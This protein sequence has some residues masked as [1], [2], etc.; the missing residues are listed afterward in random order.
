MAVVTLP[1]ATFKDYRNQ[2]VRALQVA[3]ELANA[4]LFNATDKFNMLCIP[5]NM[6]VYNIGNPITLC[7]LGDITNCSTSSSNCGGGIITL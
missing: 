1:W 6:T 5:S 2:A 7:N 3:P 4:V